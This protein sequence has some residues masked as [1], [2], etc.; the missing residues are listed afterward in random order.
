MAVNKTC[1]DFFLAK[2][3]IHHSS[4]TYTPQQNGVVERKHR[5]LLNTAR[6]LMIQA[7][8]PIKFW[9]ESIQIATHIINRV[10]LKSIGNQTAYEKK[11]HLLQT[12][13]I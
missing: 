6:A 3:I 1:N 5:H 2:G 8:L 13:I 7:C 12:S 10:P 4:C 9:E 11:F